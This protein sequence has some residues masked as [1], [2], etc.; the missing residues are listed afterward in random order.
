MPSDAFHSGVALKMNEFNP[1]IMSN[2][3]DNSGEHFEL[4]L[5]GQHFTDQSQ[6]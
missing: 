3:S 5:T 4:I 6:A 1:K 2:C